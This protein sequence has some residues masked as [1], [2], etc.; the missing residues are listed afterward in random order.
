MEG[1]RSFQ[2]KVFSHIIARESLIVAILE[3]ALGKGKC[4]DAILTASD[5]LD[6]TFI[7]QEEL[8]SKAGLFI[9]GSAA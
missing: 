1:S 2:L 6:T 5:F 7:L 9:N 3:L 8:V 4:H